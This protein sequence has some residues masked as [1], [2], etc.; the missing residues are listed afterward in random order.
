MSISR[1]TFWTTPRVSCTFQC[2][3]LSCWNRASAWIFCFVVYCM[4]SH[5][6]VRI[7]IFPAEPFPV[8]SLNISKTFPLFPATLVSEIRSKKRMW[9]MTSILLRFRYETTRSI[10]ETLQG[11]YLARIQR[12]ICCT[13][14]ISDK[15]GSAKP[16]VS[17]RRIGC[18]PCKLTLTSLYAV[19]SW[20]TLSREFPEIGS[21]KGL[22]EKDSIN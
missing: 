4:W 22:H 11:T 7:V 1:Y 5:I 12:W 3:S 2:T 19:R 16:G 10:E 14:V 18:P 15:L 13:T 17:I 20:V 6:V 9:F 8:S 21:F